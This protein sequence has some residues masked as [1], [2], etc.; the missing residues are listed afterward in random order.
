LFK[1]AQIRSQLAGEGICD[2]KHLS[3]KL[4]QHETSIE[5]LNNLRTWVELQV[6]LKKNQTID[7]EI[8]ELIKK[9]TLHWKHVMVR[10]IVVVKCL[11]IHNLAFRGT[12]ENIYEESNGNF[13]GLL[14]M[15]AEF[16]LVMQHHFRLI[17][18]KMI[19]YHYLSHKIQNELIEILTSKVKNTIIEK[20]K[21]AKYFSVILDC[22][23]DA[24]HKEQ[25]P[26]IIRCVEVSSNPIKIEEY[27]LEFLNVVDTFGLAFFNELQDVL[28]SYSLNIDNVRGQS[29]D[30]GSNMKGK[31]IGVQ[32]KSA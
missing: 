6:R 1:K 24:S 22:T 25:M 3:E 11:G 30:N 16:D 7:K 28:N 4:T 29:Y 23:P 20:I 31:N 19:H 15:I 17:Q 14:E 10:I 21:E 26:L 13:L 2:W 12:N 8:Q 32:K 27:F 5:H 18:D 9:D